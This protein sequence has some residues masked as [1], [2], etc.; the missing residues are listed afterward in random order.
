MSLDQLNRLFT[1]WVETV[2]HLTGHSETGQPPL[3]RWMTGAPFP[4]PAAAALAEAFLWS[5]YRTV[6][7]TALVSLHG[8]RYQVD[9]ALAGRRVELV[10]DP[11]DLTTLAVRAGG[12]DAGPATPYQITRHAHPK[13]RPEATPGDQPR[14]TG[15]DYLALIDTA[16]TQTLAGRVNFAALTGP[17]PEDQP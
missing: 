12:R 6:T 1:A 11:F 2:Y 17:A 13:A 4:V 14:P 10:F 5:E 7:K 3:A 8:N 9:P 16:H 15:I